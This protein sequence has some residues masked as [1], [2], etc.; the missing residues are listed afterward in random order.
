MSGYYRTIFAI[1]KG[2]APSS[3]VIGDAWRCV[4]DWVA[5]EG[6]YGAP[7]RSS[8][9]RGA[10]EGVNGDLRLYDRSLNDMRLCNLVWTRADADASGS[11]WRLSLRLATDG[12]GVEAD[13]EVRGMEGDSGETP[14]ELT[15]Q[16]PSV[17]GLLVDRFECSIGDE[18]LQTAAKRIGV[19]ESDAFV[20]D[21]IL[22]ESRRMPL[23]VVTD[24]RRG[25]NVVNANDLQHELIGLARVFAYNHNTAWNIARDLPQ[26]LWCY[27]GAV[28]LYAPGCSEDDLSQRHPYWLRWDI[29]R[30]KRD[31]RLWQML[32]DECVNRMPRQGQGRLYSRVEDRI[33]DEDMATLEDK[34][35]ALEKSLPEMEGELLDDA[36]NI[37]IQSKNTDPIDAGNSVRTG[38]FDAAIKVARAQKNRGDKFALEN[39]HLRQQIAQLEKKLNQSVPIPVELVK[40]PDDDAKPRFASV[41]AMVECAAGELT[42]LRFVPKAFETAESAYTKGFDNRADTIFRAL[43]TLNECARQRVRPESLQGKN[44][45]QW[46]AENGVTYSDESEGVKRQFWRDRLFYDPDISDDRLMTHHIKMFGDEIR[47]HVCWSR[48]EGRFLVG[49]IGEHLRTVRDPT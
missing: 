14:S 8:E 31:N 3:Q 29:D 2:D 49:H 40:E 42:H 35:V 39:G 33:N 28:R 13:I 24:F 44:E 9:Q 38:L 47:I 45:Q 19:D 17:L 27:D 11:R 10:W 15:A 34:V 21:E 12:D 18:L 20:R 7:Y 16:P 36:L 5:G 48:D 4:R 6:E 43:E 46:L 26:S 22:S 37:I 1:G 32:R 30:V 25:G 23:L 41:H